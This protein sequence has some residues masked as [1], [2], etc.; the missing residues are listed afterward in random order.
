M[1]GDVDTV[2]KSRSQAG[3]LGAQ[4]FMAVCLHYYAH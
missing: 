4:L 2:K 3:I 1:A